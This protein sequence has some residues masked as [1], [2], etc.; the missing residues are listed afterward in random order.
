MSL[1]SPHFLVALPP[2]SSHTGWSNNNGIGLA[3]EDT[4][5]LKFE[6]GPSHRGRKVAVFVAL[7][8]LF[9][10]YLLTGTSLI[11]GA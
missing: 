11:S 5:P 10:L 9:G 8:R 4:G 3:T 1:S 2:Y 6:S 7:V